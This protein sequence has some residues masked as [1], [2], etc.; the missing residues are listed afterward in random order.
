[1]GEDGLPENQN[2]TNLSVG[3]KVALGCLGLL[4]VAAIIIYVSIQSYFKNGYGLFDGYVSH[5]PPDHQIARFIS[6]QLGQG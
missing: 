2:K 5:T 3:S 4:V 6:E 1:M